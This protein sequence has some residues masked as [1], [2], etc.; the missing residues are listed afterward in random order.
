MKGS[1]KNFR[2]PVNN[3]ANKLIYSKRL[4]EI[5]DQDEKNFILR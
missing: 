1:N 2:Q 3:I 5:D 4:I